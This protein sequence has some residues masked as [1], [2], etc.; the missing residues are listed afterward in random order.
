MNEYTFENVLA[1]K[2][3]AVRSVLDLVFEQI[4]H[5]GPLQFLALFM[6]RGRCLER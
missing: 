5:L 3:S 1:N 2:L 4:T 6:E